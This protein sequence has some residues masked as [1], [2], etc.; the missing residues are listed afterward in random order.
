M[1]KTDLVGKTFDAKCYVRYFSNK[2]YG[3][4]GYRRQAL[5]D[6]LNGVKKMDRDHFC[7]TI[8]EFTPNDRVKFT[9]SHKEYGSID[10]ICKPM[11]SLDVGSINVNG[12]EVSESHRFEIWGNL[13]NGN[14][15]VKLTVE[16][17]I[18]G[19]EEGT[20]YYSYY[21]TPIFGDELVSV[22]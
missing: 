20:S 1:N 9:L 2:W 11:W 3:G 16:N 19:R 18:I 5:R 17:N 4:S 14:L 10:L 6:H 13:D 15:H 12:E 7:I 22:C 21:K 8:N